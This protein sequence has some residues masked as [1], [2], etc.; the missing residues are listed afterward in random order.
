MLFMP[1]CIL[2]IDNDDDCSF[3]QTL[4]V[5][6]AFTMYRVAYQVMKDPKDADDVVS[7]ACEALIRKLSPLRTMPRPA[8]HAYIMST[9]R[10][11]ALMIMRRRQ[12]EHRAMLRLYE[13][14]ALSA[15][16]PDPDQYLMQRVTVQEI[17]QALHCLSVI[18]QEVMRMRYFDGMSA[19]EIAEVL[20]MQ[21]AT[22]Q[23]KIKRA[24]KRLY[25]ALQEIEDEQ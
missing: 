21:L 25:A 16:S 2:A 1:I 4:Y 9:V 17:I 10:N 24:K 7:G 5:E 11:Q 23:S 3:M 20:N 15:P 12:I 8:R 18:D 13:E 22:V 14:H 19:R 6:H